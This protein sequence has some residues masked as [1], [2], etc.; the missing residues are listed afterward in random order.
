MVVS[1][2]AGGIGGWMVVWVPTKGVGLGCVFGWFMVVYG[3]LWWCG[4]VEW[5][6]HGVGIVC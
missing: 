5:W 3:G 2:G 4:V 6:C 1:N